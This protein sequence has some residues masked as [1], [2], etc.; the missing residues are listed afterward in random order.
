MKCIGREGLSAKIEVTEKTLLLLHLF[1]RAAITLLMTK[2]MLITYR[3][4]KLKFV[5]KNILV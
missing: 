3:F 2:K 1:E 5:S 4:K